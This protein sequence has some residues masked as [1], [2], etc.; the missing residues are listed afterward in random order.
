MRI[1]PEECVLYIIDANG[2]NKFDIESESDVCVCVCVFI[3]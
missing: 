2:R 3:C 1:D